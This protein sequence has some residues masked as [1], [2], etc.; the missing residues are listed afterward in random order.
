M[1]WW[2]AAR[3]AHDIATDYACTRQAFGKP[4]IEHE[5]VGFMLARNE[6]D[7]VQTQL[8]IDRVAWTL[9][10]GSKGTA[11]SSMAKYA[12]GEMLYAIAD[13]CVQVLGGLGI[14]DETPVGQI[15]REIRAFRIYDGPSE[16]HL[17]SLANR[18]QRGWQRKRAKSA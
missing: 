16:V 8:M 13:R 1:R 9:D 12:C 6:V 7:L 15:F 3:R 17:W 4:L 10:Q 14:T 5:G 11:E 2:G 18:V